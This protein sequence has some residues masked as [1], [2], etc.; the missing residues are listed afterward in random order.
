M[1]PSAAMRADQRHRISNY[2]PRLIRNYVA[3]TPT[4]F[5]SRITREALYPHLKIQVGFRRSPNL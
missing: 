5:V 4:A 1:R 3:N 2:Q